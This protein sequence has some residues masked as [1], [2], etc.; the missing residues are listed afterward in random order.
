[1]N[2]IVAYTN[3]YAYIN[4]VQLYK[5][6][7]HKYWKTT[8][9]VMYVWKIFVW[10]YNNYI[11]CLSEWLTLNTLTTIRKTKW[12]RTNF[13]YQYHFFFFIYEEKLLFF[14]Y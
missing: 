12:R 8:N 9:N 14:I 7:R 5:Y 11:I 2:N 6:A 1:M 3:E 13:L 4:S 10:T